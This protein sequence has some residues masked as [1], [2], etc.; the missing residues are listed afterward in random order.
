[1]CHVHECS[2]C[3][4]ACFFAWHPNGMVSLHVSGV[5]P[6]H[7]AMIGSFLFCWNPT[8]CNHMYGKQSIY[9]SDMHSISKPQTA[10]MKGLVWHAHR[11]TFDLTWQVSITE[12]L[13]FKQASVFS[14]LHPVTRVRLGLW[15]LKGVWMNA[16]DVCTK[17]HTVFRV[18]TING[19]A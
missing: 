11:Q 8:W 4:Y 12:F 13:L 1:M 10:P 2:F 16:H 14:C 19:P 6:Q 5:N 15:T 18:L 9:G 17:V 3:I 7:L